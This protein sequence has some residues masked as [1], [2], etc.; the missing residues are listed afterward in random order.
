[1]NTVN[2]SL[3]YNTIYVDTPNKDLD[4][5][6]TELLE[7]PIFTMVDTNA[8]LA[9]WSPLPKLRERMRIMELWGFKYATLLNWRKS[10]DLDNGYWYR[11]NCEPLLIGSRGI[12][13]VSSLTKHNLIACSEENRNYKPL[14]IRHMISMAAKNSFAIP[15]KLDLWSAYWQAEY[16]DYHPGSWLTLGTRDLWVEYLSKHVDRIN[17]NSVK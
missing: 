15:V 4:E 8:I 5:Y 12:T 11:G 2:K 10:S 1:M 17:P 3:K 6:L 13:D 7:E 14:M 9:M 16:N